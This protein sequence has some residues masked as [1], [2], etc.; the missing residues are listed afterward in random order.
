LR[1]RKENYQ[2]SMK[3]FEASLLEPHRPVSPPYII[4]W[5]SELQSMAG[6]ANA[7]GGTETGG[8]AHGL[9]THSGRQ[10]IMYTT[11]P[12]KN[13]IHEVAR[14]VQNI[15]F[16]KKT[17]SYLSDNYGIQCLGD[18]HSHHLLKLKGPSWRDNQAS[19]SMAARN[20][21]RS[22]CQFILTFT[23]ERSQRGGSLSDWN[24]RTATVDQASSNSSHWRNETCFASPGHQTRLIEI[25]A[26]LYQKPAQIQPV[27]CPLRVIPGISPIRQA[28]SNNFDIPELNKKYDFPMS[29]IIFDSFESKPEPHFH[30]DLP[31]RM[32]RQLLR[33]PREI[34][35]DARVEFK[36]DQYILSLPVHPIGTLFI[37]YAKE[38]HKALDVYFVRNNG[39]DGNLVELTSGVLRFGPFM[40]LTTIFSLALSMINGN[41]RFD[42]SS[43]DSTI[44]NPRRPDRTLTPG[45]EKQTS[46]GWI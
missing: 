23:D 37:V 9:L 42:G 33:L 21:Y 28:I 11:P 35:A 6:I 18:F 13:A 41:R 15:G 27:R 30:G 19:H 40:N 45:T 3:N 20:G 38:P 10:V 24:R 4:I 1:T 2:N 16:L 36:G 25:R 26:F 5:E 46:G 7:Y 22:F 14:F 34:L 44:V 29:R 31:K 17:N 12:G 32:Y 43:H 8:G 39:D